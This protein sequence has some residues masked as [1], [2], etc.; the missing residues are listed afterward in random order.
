[1]KMFDIS[2]ILPYLKFAVNPFADP[3]ESERNLT[4]S[5]KPDVVLVGKLDPQKIPKTGPTESRSLTST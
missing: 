5:E 2:T 1:M 3:K 4:Q